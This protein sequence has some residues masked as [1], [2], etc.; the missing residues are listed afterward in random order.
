VRSSMSFRATRELLCQVAP[1]SPRFSSL[2]TMARPAAG[3]ASHW[4]P[5]TWRTRMDPFAAV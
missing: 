5:R 2:P 4:G 1:R 3:T